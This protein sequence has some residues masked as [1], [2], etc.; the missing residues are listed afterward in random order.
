MSNV[1]IIRDHLLHELEHGVRTTR[2]VVQRIQPDQWEYRPKENMRTLLELTRHLVMLP[3]TDLAIIR[4]MQGGPEFERIEG[5]VQGITDAQQLSGLMQEQF[6]AM[7][8]YFLSLTEEEFLDK[9]TK[10]FYAD[11]GSVQV[12]WLIEVVTHVFHHRAQLFNYL[13]ELGHEI[14][15]FDLY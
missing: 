10:P 5:D 9:Y 8:D 2:G 14:N 4:E 1:F 7:K 13:K 11:Q 3:A 6:E 12:K 15:M